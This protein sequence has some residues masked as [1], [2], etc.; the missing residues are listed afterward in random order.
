MANGYFERGE[1]YWVKMGTGIGVEMN[2]TRPGLIVSCDEMNQKLDSVLVAF[3]TTR[4]HEG[5]GPWNNVST[6]ATGRESWILC[7][8]IQTVD[9]SRFAK[10]LGVLNSAE[11][12]EVEGCLEHV[13]DLGYQDDAALKAKDLEID[14][15]NA[16]I[17]EKDAEIT[18]LRAQMESRNRE[19]ESDLNGYKIE[20]AVYR[21]LYEKSLDYTVDM[22]FA[23]D[24]ARRKSVEEPAVVEVPE[25]ELVDINHCTITA[26]KK[27]GFSL[28]MGKKIVESR[29]FTSV[30]DLK[31]V[32][33]LKS[34]MFR[35]VEQ[36]LCCTPV[37][38]ESVTVE[39]TPDPGFEPVDINT[40]GGKDLIAVGFAYG[41]AYKIT[42][43]RK[44]NGPF[45]SVDDLRRA[46]ISQKMI[47]RFR[48]HLTAVVADPEVIEDDGKLNVNEA[49]VTELMNVGFTKS[50]ANTIVAYRL[51]NGPYDNVYDLLKL[52]DVTGKTLR[53][54]GDKVRV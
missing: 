51:K 9:K 25:V 31:R 29:P 37:E 54:L 18:R 48:D 21:K 8:Q 2:V 35:V 12:R 10:M 19:H 16:V 34:S 1:I 44:K 47:D 32:N 17:A 15:R 24:I 26:L 36:K 20:A 43:D 6:D 33:G 11:M 46:S 53:K 52:T 42:S 38:E 7:D 50:A 14:A 27:L 13:F 5:R 23:S 3:L 4:D 45:S 40:C 22:K 28:P 39:R 49:T 30:E 41:T